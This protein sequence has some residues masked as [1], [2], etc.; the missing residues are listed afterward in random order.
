[1]AGSDSAVDTLFRKAGIVRCY[2]KEELCYVAGVFSHKELTGKNIAVITH[3]GGPGVMLT[4]SLSK[5]NM[6]V[7]HLEGEA[8]DELMTA[9]NNPRFR[10]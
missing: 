2:S 9:W 10:R 8:A 4:D 1:L 5:G 3:A 6:E 7:P